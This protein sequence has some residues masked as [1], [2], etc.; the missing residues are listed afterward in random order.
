METYKRL[1]RVRVELIRDG[2]V[3][4]P[5]RS[6]AHSGDAARIIREH[7]GGADREQFVVIALDSNNR[8]IA[9]HTAT[10]GTL[11][12][13]LITPR[14]VFKFA[15]LAN[16]SAVIL[17]HNHPSGNPRPS[18]ED[19]QATKRLASAGQVVGITVVDHVIVTETDYTSMSLA[20]HLDD[21]AAWD[22]EPE[23]QFAK[24]ERERA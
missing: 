17:G 13:A 15:L 20:G 24:R 8:A 11:G 9:I 4:V 12:H 6:C 1:P 18:D 23:E 10:V 2:S 5:T 14:E 3:R 7:I 19:I 21:D 16:A 22:L